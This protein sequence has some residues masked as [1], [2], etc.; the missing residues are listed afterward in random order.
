MPVPE[1]LFFQGS[2]W[3]CIYYIHCYVAMLEKYGESLYDAK[4]GGNSS[5]ALIALAI[6][7][8]ASPA[9][10][11]AVYEQLAKRSRVEG[12]WGRMSI[13]HSEALAALMP[14]GDEYKQ[15][16][17][18]L[19]IGITRFFKRHELISRWNSQQEL[20]DTMHASFHI[21]L[22]C[23]YIAKVNG[24]FAIDGVFSSTS[25]MLCTNTVSIGWACV[26]KTIHPNEALID[27]SFI[28]PFSDAEVEARK[29]KWNHTNIC[30]CIAHKSNRQKAYSRSVLVLVWGLRFV[31]SLNS[32]RKRLVK[33]IACI[34]SLI[35]RYMF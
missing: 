31:E 28:K 5:G 2:S 20:I 13:Y 22:Y 3:G 4:M 7:L 10:L 27:V 18:E 19:F 8:R 1:S 30:E 33:Y 26:G 6:K 34:Y 24:Q 17:G 11:L 9:K 21:P 16:N 14:N 12:V 32:T 23:S 29:D 35:L 15:L 25:S